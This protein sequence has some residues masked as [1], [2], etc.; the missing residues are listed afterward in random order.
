MIKDLPD[1]EVP[2]FWRQQAKST[3][4]KPAKVTIKEIVNKVI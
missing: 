3:Y 1:D 4:K 2:D